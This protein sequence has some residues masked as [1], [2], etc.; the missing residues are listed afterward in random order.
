MCIFTSDLRTNANHWNGLASS[1]LFNLKAQSFPDAK[2]THAIANDQAT[3]DRPRRGLEM[4][5][6]GSIDPPNHLIVKKSCKRN[7][8]HRA[9][10]TLDAPAKIVGRSR[11]AKLT[12]KFSDFFCIVESESA[13]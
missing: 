3:D 12:A 7:A 6:D 9:C 8:V 10:S 5:F 13:N 11:I 1:P 4:V 2:S